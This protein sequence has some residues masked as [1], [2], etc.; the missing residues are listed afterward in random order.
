VHGVRIS[1]AYPCKFPVRPE[2][3]AS[4]TLAAVIEAEV[5]YA[6]KHEYAQTAIDVLARRT[7]LSFLNAQA[8][9]DALPRVIDIMAE[10]CGWSTARKAAE[11]ARACTFLTSMGLPASSAAAAS[12]AVPKPTTLA[13][14]IEHALHTGLGLRAPAHKP[15]T[16]IHGR[17]Q[18]DAAE[19]DAFKSA[20]RRETGADAETLPRVAVLG[21]VKSLP[22]YENVSQKEYEYVLVETGL[23]GRDAF[24]MDEFVEVRFARSMAFG[25]WCWF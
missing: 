4:L 10:E 2:L 24:D 15:T 19:M 21:L 5:R 16:L 11:I 17:A 18:V 9:L 6:V 8:A 14:R 1:P 23:K 22:G 3:T 13:G 7:R 12:A 25:V 20:F